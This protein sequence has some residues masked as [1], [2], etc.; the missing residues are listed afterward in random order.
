M[1][2]CSS[3]HYNLTYNIPPYPPF[4]ISVDILFGVHT[5]YFCSIFSY[6]FLHL[7][8]FFLSPTLSFVFLPV[9]SLLL[10]LD[11]YLNFFAFVISY[12]CAPLSIINSYFDT[13]FFIIITIVVWIEI[14]FNATIMISSI[15]LGIF[16]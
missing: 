9:I 8:H 16:L 12:A 3:S 1:L 2:K 6:L 7:H 14:A 10:S 4:F 13:F 11:I 5:F 15:V